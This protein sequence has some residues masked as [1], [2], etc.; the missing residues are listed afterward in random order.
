MQEKHLDRWRSAGLPSNTEIH[1]MS[2][3]GY[4][5]LTNLISLFILPFC[6]FSPPSLSS[7]IL[8]QTSPLVFSLSPAV[9]SSHECIACWPFML[10]FKEL[11]VRGR[12]VLHWRRLSSE[13]HEG[14][15]RDA[16]L[17]LQLLIALWPVNLTFNTHGCCQILSTE[18]E[19]HTHILCCPWRCSLSRSLSLHMCVCSLFT[20]VQICCCPWGKGRKDWRKWKKEIQ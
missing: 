2:G 1:K 18:I 14:S 19:W 17:C 9:F 7:S 10:S 20:G 16:T 15:G 3:V 8:T 11:R 13:T 4:P 12:S 6:F 5:P